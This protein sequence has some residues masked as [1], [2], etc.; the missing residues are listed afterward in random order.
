[1]ADGLSRTRH[2]ADYKTGG[3]SSRSS[4]TQAGM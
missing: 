3:R 2:L 4:R 1:M